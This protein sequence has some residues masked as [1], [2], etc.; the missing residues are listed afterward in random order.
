MI[1]QKY[2]K[3]NEEKRHLEEQIDDISNEK[4]NL[5]DQ[6]RE[7]QDHI[8]DIEGQSDG[9]TFDET[10]NLNGTA[11]QLGHAA[12]WECKDKVDELENALS[13]SFNETARYKL[14]VDMARVNQRQLVD[15][16]KALKIN[17]KGLEASNNQQMIQLE[18]LT[19]QLDKYKMEIDN[20]KVILTTRDATVRRL[21]AEVNVAQTM[22]QES[23][24]QK[25]QVDQEELHEE[26]LSRNPL[27]GTD[28]EEVKIF[29]NQ[30]TQLEA[31]QRYHSTQ[32][33]SPE[34]QNDIFQ[35]S[36]PHQPQPV[37]TI[38]HPLNE[39][40]PHV[41]HRS[42]KRGQIPNFHGSNKPN[43]NIDN[44]IFLKEHR[45]QTQDIKGASQRNMRSSICAT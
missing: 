13:R 10:N 18:A 3:V 33:I 36:I 4:L 23:C 19:I 45:F 29:T 32:L 14:E 41:R 30:V 27:H 21:Q 5:Q 44:W 9:S 11:C 25:V 12:I 40:Q 24:M 15:E 43:D 6:I 35:S 8:D 20:I 7:L 17:I 2:A 34:R 37:G 16:N 28:K 26:N 39:S 42:P 22:Y 31:S 1:D 38:A